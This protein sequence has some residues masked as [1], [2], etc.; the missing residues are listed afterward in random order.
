MMKG[1][2]KLQSNYTRLIADCAEMRQAVLKEAF[3]G[4]L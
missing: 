3:E 1:A 2:I 4:R